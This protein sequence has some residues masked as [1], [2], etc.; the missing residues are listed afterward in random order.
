ME[1][2]LWKSVFYRPIEE[3]RRRIK[4][5]AA[6]GEKGRAPLQK[7]GALH[8]TPVTH[9][10]EAGCSDQYLMQGV[11]SLTMFCTLAGEVDVWQILARCCAV[12]QAACL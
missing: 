11:Y 8:A 6:A 1:P 4:A 12:L 9:N 3:F 10:Y 5:A 7:V 2:A